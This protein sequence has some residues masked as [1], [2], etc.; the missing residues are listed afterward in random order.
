[1]FLARPLAAQAADAAAADAEEPAAAAAA[2][3]AAGEAARE[4]PAAATPAHSVSSAS[5]LS[6]YLPDFSCVVRAIA[7]LPALQCLRIDTVHVDAAVVQLAA[8]PAAAALTKLHLTDCALEDAYLLPVLRRMQ[9]LRKLNVSHNILLSNTVLEAAAAQLTGLEELDV[10]FSGMTSAAADSVRIKLP[11]L[12]ALQAG[13]PSIHWQV[14]AI[15]GFAA[16]NNA[17]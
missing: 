7:G 8:G 4:G 6:R 5:A 15:P 13:R 16:D 3:A 12:T 17:S 1:M 10:R 14:G 11:Q 9:A 2:A